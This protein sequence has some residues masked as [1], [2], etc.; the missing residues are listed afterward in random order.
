MDRWSLWEEIDDRARGESVE[1]GSRS[2]RGGFHEEVVHLLFARHRVRVF[3]LSP[4][5]SFLF[6]F[7][8]GRARATT[9]TFFLPS[10]VGV[11]GEQ[12]I[13][14]NL[15]CRLPWD[16]KREGAR[17]NLLFLHRTLLTLINSSRTNFLYLLVSYSSFADRSFVIRRHEFCGRRGM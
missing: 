13:R 1:E 3:L 15:R 10:S 9:V 4:F 16:N 17:W 2:R 8:F 6:G 12:E 5:F 11:G 7:L 14:I